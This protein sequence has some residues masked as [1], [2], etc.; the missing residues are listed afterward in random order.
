LAEWLRQVTTEEHNI[1]WRGILP[2]SELADQYR[3]SAF[4]VYPSL[5]EGFG[6]PIL[7]SLWMDTPCL[8]HEGGV[9]A[10]L[11]ADGGCLTVDMSDVIQ[12]MEGLDALL[13]NPD[14]R[15]A[16]RRQARRRSIDTW[17]DYAAA[18]AG[19]LRSLGN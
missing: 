4:T 9:M 14:L 7:E 3:R 8:C 2:D 13:T 15:G 16:L 17:S 12:V 11:A 5:A 19:R 18:I 6:L 1:I 10:E